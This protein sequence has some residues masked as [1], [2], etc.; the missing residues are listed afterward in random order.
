MRVIDKWFRWNA[1]RAWHVLTLRS[2]RVR[3]LMAAV[4]RGGR[5]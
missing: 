5:R 1:L 2:V 3:R 4:R